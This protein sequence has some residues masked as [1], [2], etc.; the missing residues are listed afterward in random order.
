MSAES[1][2][3]K[4]AEASFERLRLWNER[5]RKKRRKAGRDVGRPGGWDRMLERHL[6]CPLVEVYGWPKPEDVPRL[7]R[8]GGNPYLRFWERV[9]GPRPR[10]A[11]ND[12]IA[13]EFAD[14][15]TLIRAFPLSGACRH[16]MRASLATH[17]SR[18]Y[19]IPF[20]AHAIP[21]RPAIATIA[22]LDKPVLEL[23]SGRGYWAWQL[24]Q[25]GVRVVCEEPHAYEWYWRAPERVH[26]RSLPRD[27]A[28]FFCWPTYD[29]SWPARALR[30][31][32]GNTVIYV[33]EGDGGCT[34][35]AAF[36]RLLEQRFAETERIYIPQWD[37][38]HDELTIWQR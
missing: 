27:H 36:H 10:F 37:G 2:F 13:P 28:L 33:G 34:A 1:L 12:P 29:V 24:E 26:H 30:E 25:S 19:A 21:D 22:E 14:E 18:S 35:D 23:G 20:Y 31:F 17:A 5:Q 38:I 8:E 9:C 32:Q 11:L 4:E 16:E 3:S 6:Q 15:E 7:L